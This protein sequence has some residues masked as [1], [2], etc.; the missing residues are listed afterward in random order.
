MTT[1]RKDYEALAAIVREE[2]EPL[3]LLSAEGAVG[4]NIAEKAAD[5]FAS[6]NPRFDRHL[7]LVACGVV[8]CTEPCMTDTV[9][10]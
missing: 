7:F 1:S 4:C 9:W 10:T 3:S 6:V 8:R 5:Y 2:L